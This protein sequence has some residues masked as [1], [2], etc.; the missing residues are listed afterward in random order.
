MFV[1]GCVRV[2]HLDMN[3]QP[4]G[5]KRAESE[6]LSKKRRD[7]RLP[8]LISANFVPPP[9][10]GESAFHT[11]TEDL[12]PCSNCPAHV[13]RRD[14]SLLLLHMIIL[15]A[16]ETAVSKCCPGGR[17]TL[18]QW[19]YLFLPRHGGLAESVKYLNA[20]K[21]TQ[22]SKT[23]SQTQAPGAIHA[24]MVTPPP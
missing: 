12:H 13:A 10:G 5:R 23:F 22:I 6:H 2:P 4:R 19:S 21:T 3:L 24:S 11:L 15:R 18:P 8:G 16:C 17:C 1:H 7:L 9:A 14:R 20:K